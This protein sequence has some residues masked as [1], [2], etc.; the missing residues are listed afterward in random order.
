MAKNNARILIPKFLEVSKVRDLNN[1]V[2]RNT[3][4]FLFLTIPNDEILLPWPETA[5]CDNYRYNV[6]NLYKMYTDYGHYFLWFAIQASQLPQESAFDDVEMSKRVEKLSK[7]Q[8]RVT[9]HYSFVARIARHVITHGI[10]QR[11]TTISPYT[12]PKIDEMERV[13][14]EL[15]SEKQ[16]PQSQSDWTK[17]NKWLVQ[18]ADFAYNWLYSWAEIW[19]KCSK[20]KVELE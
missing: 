5:G 20:E 15:L 2:Y 18:E 14:G 1:F 8:S 6:I 11:R 7:E 9:K 17:I 3:G 16:W 10:F 12:D 19:N 13:F 4:C